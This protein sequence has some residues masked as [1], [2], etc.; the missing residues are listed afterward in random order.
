MGIIFLGSI[1]SEPNLKSMSKEKFQGLDALGSLEETST[2]STSQQVDSSE[3][4][5]AHTLI[6]MCGS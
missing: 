3:T 1:L 2:P 4:A 5:G 6:I